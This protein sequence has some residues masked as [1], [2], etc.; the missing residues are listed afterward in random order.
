MSL[1]NNK[2][3]Q[4]MRKTDQELLQNLG[5]KA[6]S[7]QSRRVDEIE[8][9]FTDIKTS[10]ERLIEEKGDVMC[11]PSTREEVL[12]KAKR[13]LEDGK[14]FVKAALAKHLYDCQQRS[15]D[16][17]TIS[18]CEFY[19]GATQAWKLFFYALDE[20]DIE[21]AVSALPNIGIPAKQ[22]EKRMKEIDSEI[23]RLS[24]TLTEK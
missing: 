11:G 15:S 8:K 18:F 2:E 14:R 12:A 3:M 20:K 4:A 10:I 17:F 22:K 1:L 13:E 9:R 7:I 16:P 24:E 23:T 6:D 21:E 5:K 19:F